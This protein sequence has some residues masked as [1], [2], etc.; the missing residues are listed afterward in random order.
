MRRWIGRIALVLLVVLLVALVAGTGFAVITVRS[1]FPQTSG[2][3]TVPGLSAPVEVRRDEW[4]IPNITADTAEDLFRAQGYVSA[5]DRFWEMDFRR[6]VT[7]GRLSELFGDSQL[8]TDRFIR[9]MGWRRV[10]EQELELLD[11]ET[12][13]Y[14]EAY[15][16]GV[17]AYLADRSG[18]SLSLEYAV[19]GLQVS[20]YEP[21]PWTPADSVA[22]LKAMAWNLAGGLSEEVQRV[23]WSLYLS[24]EQL[25][26]VD[27]PYPFDRAPVIV[28]DLTDATAARAGASTASAARTDAWAA[29]NSLSGLAAMSERVRGML[30]GGA[31]GSGIGSNS[32]AISGALTA[33]GLPILA[34]DPHLA[35][36]M[37]GIW[38][39]VGLH[40]RTVNDA[41]PF[42]VSGFS[43]SGFP[44]V[45][46]GHNQRI[47]WG[48][49]N[50]AADVQDIYLEDVQGNQ[51]RVGSRM[52][53]LDVRTE[54]IQ[55]AGGDPVTIRIRSTSHGPLLSDADDW[56]RWVGG[57][58]P[59]P[60]EDVTTTS[61]D[62]ALQWTALQPGLTAQAV[63]LIDRSQ[64]FDD[65]REAARRFDGPS[66]NMLYAD[67][68]GH[69]GY[70]A[71][72]LI[73]IRR[74]GDGKWPVPGWDAA[75]GWD[76]FVP[77]EDMPWMFDPED[78]YIVTANNA[79]VTEDY[80][81]FLTDDWTLGDRASR[82]VDLIAGAADPFTVDSAAALAFDQHSP[83][84]DVLA[85]A[86]E[87]LTLEG[88]AAQAM[89]LLDGWD[90][91][92]SADSAAAA[93]LN[94]VW[95]HVAANTYNDEL[96]HA[97]FLADG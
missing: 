32:F 40:C 9:T 16:D 87:R 1:S 36:S 81:V 55:V 88:T 10:A 7:S 92:Q 22:W 29:A 86:L 65:F 77:F 70:Q 28:T 6:H 4:G 67:V 58:A 38:T 27:P 76:G 54:T 60:S 74:T 94:A 47:A 21:E 48:F 93:F 73:P 23:V 95:S 64:D 63:F 43:F 3:A 24:E 83:V 18:S 52:E 12:M 90:G 97:D 33:S 42:D 8:G 39:Q 26:D 84:V 30:G 51:V 89:D 96:F 25:A 71:P 62:V 49:T 59:M 5:Q 31:A 14:L 44:G 19:L 46:L 91:Q 69:I 15:A 13:G 34:N 61:P 85:P 11:E 79:V 35:P 17:N 37:P 50:L 68:D 53:D 72:G 2:E 78:G 75:Y 80:P 57:V 41:C 82:I 45:V 66:Q 56:Y 20:G